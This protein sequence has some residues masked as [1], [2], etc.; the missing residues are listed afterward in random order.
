MIKA[1]DFITAIKTMLGWG[2]VLGAQGELYSKEMAQKFYDEYHEKSLSYYMDDCSKWFGKNVVD[3][4]GLIIQAIRSAI[5]GYADQ[6]A[7]GLYNACSEKG[8]ISTIPEIP[9]ICVRK[10]GHIGVYIGNGEVI[11]SRGFAYGV[12]TTKLSDRPWTHW[13]KLKDV[14]YTIAQTAVK[15]TFHISQ[16]LKKGMNNS[17]VCHITRNLTALGFINRNYTSI[18]DAQVEQ[19]VKAFQKKYHLTEDGIVGKQTTEALGGVWD[20]K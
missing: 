8:S 6:N 19:A 16:I 15:P 4:S 5:P 14:D 3:C 9:G 2:Y 13:G 20:G 11:E 12:V 7:D 10:S 17:Q 18:F 1:N